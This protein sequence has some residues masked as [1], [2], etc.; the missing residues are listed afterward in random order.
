MR[1]LII[2]WFLPLSLCCTAVYCREHGAPRAV[3]ANGTVIQWYRTAQGTKDR[4]TRQPDV[5]FGPDFS[6]D[7][8][9]YIN[10]YNG[11]V[12]SMTVT[13]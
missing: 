6:S 9:I 10:R 4:L 8:V 1:V 7:A 5:Q 3:A 12:G 2:S 13:T 11:E